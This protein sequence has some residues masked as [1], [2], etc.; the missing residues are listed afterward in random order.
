WSASLALPAGTNTFSIYAQA[1]NGNFSTTNFYYIVYGVSNQLDLS[2]NGLGIIYPNYSNAWLRVGENYTVTA[3][4]NSGFVFT[5]WTSSNGASPG[6]STNKVTL[7]FMMASNMTLQAN[8]AETAKPTLTISSPASGTHIGNTLP[9]VVGT[10]SDPWQVAVV[11]FRLNNGSWNQ[12][13]TT[14]YFKNWWTTNSLTFTA[15]TNTF[16]AYAVNL[17]GNYSI[18]NNLVL[19]STNSAAS[20]LMPGSINGIKMLLS[21]VTLP[22][23]KGGLSLNL[24]VPPNANGRILVSTDMINWTVLTSFAAGTNSTI[25]IY[26]PTATTN[27]RRFYRAVTP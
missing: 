23:A 15:A 19:I 4:P 10:A 7:Q 12:A 17:G 8:F 6:Y 5:N 20:D 24:S 18:T 22:S 25:S 11:W 2:A 26:D 21:F 14:N 1:T 9:T 16:S 3:Y 27:G 13:T